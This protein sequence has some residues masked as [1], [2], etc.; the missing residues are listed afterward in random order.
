MSE[1][2][3][4]QLNGKDREVSSD[5][6]VR[7]LIVSL[8][9]APEMIVVER[10]RAILRRDDYADVSVEDGDVIELVHFVGGG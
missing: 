7:D 4:I 3:H 5:L 8:D 6:S 1:P 9:L 2:I 10:N